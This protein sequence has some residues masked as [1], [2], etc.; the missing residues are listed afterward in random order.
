MSLRDISSFPYRS[1]SP[2]LEPLGRQ[3]IRTRRTW[4]WRRNRHQS[5]RTP[6]HCPCFLIHLRKPIPGLPLQRTQ[7]C[8]PRRCSTLSEALSESCGFWKASRTVSEQCAS[9]HWHFSFSP[10]GSPHQETPNTKSAAFLFSLSSDPSPSPIFPGF[11]F[12]MGPSQDEVSSRRKRWF[13][14]TTLVFLNYS[15]SCLLYRAHPLV[16]LGLFSARR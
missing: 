9:S 1:S 15:V 3:R 5:G 2:A 16:S 4:L 11:R 12:D 14:E 10:H 13:S 6:R 7:M 8:S